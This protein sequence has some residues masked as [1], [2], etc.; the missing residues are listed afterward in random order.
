MSAITTCS[1]LFRRRFRPLN[2]GGLN[3]WTFAHSKPSQCC[4]SIG[5]SLA[6]TIPLN[7]GAS[8]APSAIRSYGSSLRKCFGWYA[9]QQHHRPYMTEICSMVLVYCVGDFCAQLLGPDGFDAHRT[10][11]SITI[12]ALV[13]IPSRKWFLF[14]GRN[15]NY[16]SAMVSTWTKVVVNQLVY[17]SLF[18]VYF[19]ASHAI[20]SGLTFSGVIERVKNTVPTSLPRSFLIWPFITAFNFT[21]VQPQSRSVVTA[22]FSVFWQSYLSWLNAQAQKHEK[23]HGLSAWR[24]SGMVFGS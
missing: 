8:L 15:F 7:S 1:A 4:M 13:A 11:R 3:C 16:S 22:I 9:R 14:L 21:Y 6:K 10:L 5:R 24:E 2:G 23:S 18:N 17:T 20:L 19:F 12:G